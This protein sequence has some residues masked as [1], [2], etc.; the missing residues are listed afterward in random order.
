MDN[1]DEGAK[2]GQADSD[3]RPATVTFV[4][5]EHFTLQGARSSTIAESTGRAWSSPLPH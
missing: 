2:P 3:P 5:T 1:T 4:T